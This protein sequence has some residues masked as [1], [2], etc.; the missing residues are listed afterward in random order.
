MHGERRAEFGY[1]PRVRLLPLFLLSCSS[2]QPT[3]PPVSVEPVENAPSNGIALARGGAELVAIELP[4]SSRPGGEETKPQVRCASEFEPRVTSKGTGGYTCSL[5][6]SVFTG[7][8]TRSAPTGMRVKQGKKTLKY[9]LEPKGRGEGT[10][11]VTNGTLVVR[12]K[13][14]EAPTVDG[15]AIYYPRATDEERSRNLHTSELEP[16]AFAFRSL[17]VGNDTAYGA[18][19][20][21]P[22]RVSFRLTVPH[23]GVLQSQARILEPAVQA[24]GTSDGAFVVV[25]VELNKEREQV[26]RLKLP[27]NGRTKPLH[28]DL[29]AYAGKEVVLHISTDPGGSPDF[30]Y[31]FLEEPAVYTP[32]A[33]PRRVILVFV[34]TLRADHLGMYGYDRP[35]SPK[36]DAWA[37]GAVVFE[38]ARSVAPW[39]LPSA[40]S[41]LTGH[42]PEMWGAVPHVAEQFANAGYVTRAFSNNAYLTPHFDMGRQWSSFHYEFMPPAPGVVDQ[43][44]AQIEGAEDRDLFMMVHLMDPHLPY[45]EP[46]DYA[47]L[48][49]SD[50]P[51]YFEGKI[52]LST[53]ENLELADAEWDQVAMPYLI[54]R[55]DQNIRVIDDAVARLIEAAGDQATVVLFSDHGE[56]FRD[57]GGFEHGQSLYDELLRVPL[58]IKSPGLGA[59]KVT[60]PVSLIDI[61]PTLVDLAGLPATETQ[62]VSLLPAARGDAAALTSLEN[63]KLSFGRTLYGTQSWGV[64]MSGRKAILRDDALAVFELEVDPEETNNLAAMAPPDPDGFRV[65]L[66][67]GL[68]QPTS[69]AWR[70]IGP[71]EG[72]GAVVRRATVR[73]AQTDGFTHAWH[74]LD[75]TG[76]RSPPALVDNAVE[77]KAEPGHPIAREIYLV[78]RHDPRRPDAPW[79]TVET[80]D[81]V[82]R[83]DGVDF[84]APPTLGDRLIT[85]DENGRHWEVTVTVTPLPTG[86][87]VPAFSESMAAELEA[88]GYVE[89]D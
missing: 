68:N 37:E 51:A 5:P 52:S 9:V 74:G 38:Q 4:Q 71:G 15:V 77:M 85:L 47:S 60:P 59:A 69:W 21:T 42:Q 35:T 6:F 30:D 26:A 1:S 18:L 61:V 55:Y 58:V 16:E 34:D 79:L 14:D 43:A 22:A 44:I 89:S 65:A 80:P 50:P 70:L 41:A 33:N 27:K 72:K 17:L 75:V 45:R 84:E 8:S 25:E 88:L 20:P 48:F 78:P 28:V 23:N 54:D 73:V 53:V 49:A 56:E 3:A 2:P 36:L 62:G 87:A 7:H 67:E 81:G 82:A 12:P 13:G 63:R 86:T 29:S 19:L 40:R 10:W 76:R 57:H 46:A 11:A 66:G 24:N 32:A 39:T 83:G 31:V 64:L